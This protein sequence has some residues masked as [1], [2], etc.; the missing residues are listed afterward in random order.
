M[1]RPSIASHAGLQGAASPRRCDHPGCASGGE[2]R[3]PRSRAELHRYYWFCLDHVRAYNTAWNYYVG[4][5]IDEIE[6]EIRRDTVWQ[7]PSW[8]LGGRSAF[9][10]D[11]RIRDHGLFGFEDGAEPVQNGHSPHRPDSPAAHALAVFNLEHPVTLSGLKARYK[12]LVKL[13]HPD[14]HGGDKEAEERLKV[15]NQ[16]YATLKVVYLS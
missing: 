16:A 12:E 1:P 2:F 15:I 13:N 9:R 14:S 4:M 7:R 10:H 11:A 5:S 8:P 3:A 6:R